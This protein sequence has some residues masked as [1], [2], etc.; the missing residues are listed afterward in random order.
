MPSIPRPFSPVHAVLLGLA[1][2]P[3]AAGA[4]PALPDTGL[5]AP[6][7]KLYRAQSEAAAKGTA[8]SPGHLKL[9][10]ATGRVDEAAALL[11]KLTGDPREADAVRV[12]VLLA[13][14]DF[15]ALEPVRKRIMAGPMDREDERS[16]LFAWRIATDDA[17]VASR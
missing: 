10:L 14:Q 11:P 17:A 16:A 6:V 9:M 4:A 2:I 3:T 12:R 13:R 5:F 7:A 1:L 15:A 8:V